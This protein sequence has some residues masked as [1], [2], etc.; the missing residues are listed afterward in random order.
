MAKPKIFISYDY[1]ND[2]HYKNML[3]AWDKNGEF[4]FAFSDHSA[5]VS[6]Q[7][8]DAEVIKRAISAKINSATYFLCIVGSKTSGSGWVAWEIEKAKELRKKIV[9]VKT[10]SDNKTP[11]GLLNAGA[12]WAMSFTFDATK[13]T[14]GS[15]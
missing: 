14:I 6:I 11:S 15:A 2:K 1:D 3:L 4:D 7:S 8:T 5:D 9:A 13:K 10:A 12:S